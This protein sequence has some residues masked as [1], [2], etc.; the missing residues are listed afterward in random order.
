MK[1][2]KNFIVIFCLA[3]VLVSCDVFKT[4]DVIADPQNCDAVIDHIG[5]NLNLS[6]MTAEVAAI[7]ATGA[8]EIPSTIKVSEKDFT[9]IS[10]GAYAAQNNHKLTAVKLPATVTIIKKLAFSNCKGL[11][12]VD[13]GEGVET[14]QS[15]AFA[16][17]ALASLVI[18]T[19]IKTITDDAFHY[20]NSIKTLTIDDSEVAL[21]WNL[22][23]GEYGL[24]KYELSS[25]YVGRSVRAV[26]TVPSTSIRI[27]QQVTKIG[28]FPLPI[29]I[30]VTLLTSIPPEANIVTNNKTLMEAQINVPEG[31]L[32]DYKNDGMWGKF[33]NI[34]AII[35]PK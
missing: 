34:N 10:I 21:D 24:D 20:C 26:R 31:A 11:V 1:K 4:E 32:E 15:E 2:L 18:P 29:P 27:G 17:S 9:V 33:W 25:I 35:D 8:V 13:F 22:K 19:N 28:Y 6:K 14:I 12:K 5:Y 7:R 23:I 30:T 16:Y 3:T